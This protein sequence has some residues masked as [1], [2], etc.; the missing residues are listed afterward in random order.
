MHGIHRKRVKE[1]RERDIGLEAPPLHQRDGE[2][3]ENFVRKSVRSWK[4]RPLHLSRHQISSSTHLWIS[5]LRLTGKGNPIQMVGHL[6][7]QR[8]STC[9]CAL[10]QFS[11][12]SSSLHSVSP[13]S[14]PGPENIPDKAIMDLSPSLFSKRKLLRLG[15]V[16]I[17]RFKSAL[18][19]F[20]ACACAMPTTS[21][22]QA[23]RRRFGPLTAAREKQSRRQKSGGARDEKEHTHMHTRTHKG[24][25]LIRERGRLF[26]RHEQD[27]R[28][29]Q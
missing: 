4:G 23:G 19:K 7:H 28:N 5:S 2:R 17:S 3:A 27:Q 20:P 13:P 12:L 29:R 25:L 16:Y 9:T 11:K 10:W 22:L 24:F 14:D 18:G 15:I 8:K 6:G 1:K 26:C 21:K